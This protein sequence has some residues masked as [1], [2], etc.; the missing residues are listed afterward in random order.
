M[1]VIEVIISILAVAVNAPGEIPFKRCDNLKHLFVVPGKNNERGT[2][3]CLD[4]PRLSLL[5]PYFSIF[6]FPHIS[7]NFLFWRKLEGQLSPAI[8]LRNDSRRIRG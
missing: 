4:L 6:W 2:S 1:L 7:P 8:F 3:K 5:L